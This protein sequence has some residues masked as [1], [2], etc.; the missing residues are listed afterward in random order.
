MNKLMYNI[1]W[2]KK[3]RNMHG[4]AIEYT[5]KKFD[6]VKFYIIIFYNFKVYYC[7]T[8]VTIFVNINCLNNIIL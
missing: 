2:N 3:E 4:Y 8:C 1:K 7:I 5:L 6:S